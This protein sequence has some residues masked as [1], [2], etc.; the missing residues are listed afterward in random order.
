MRLVPDLVLVDG[1]FE[2]GRAV[3]VA[4]G[5]IADVGPFPPPWG[6]AAFADD[7]VRL[8]GKALL[9]GTVNAH[10]HTFQS[11]L[12]RLGDELDFKAWRDRERLGLGLGAFREEGSGPRSRRNG[13]A[14]AG[15]P[16]RPP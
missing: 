13:T 1:R 9:P 10:C 11:L 2:A 3:T 5:R 4:D 16:G 12:Q 6:D 14:T 8:P 7:L 15:T